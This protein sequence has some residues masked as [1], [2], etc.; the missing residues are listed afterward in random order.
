MTIHTIND[1]VKN[2]DI[3]YCIDEYVR[4]VEYREILRKHWFHRTTI[5]ALAEE[6]HI[7]ETAVKNVIYGLGDKIL[8]KAEKM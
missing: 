6:Y 3:E 2:S 4:P 5:S 7:S 8:L 1:E